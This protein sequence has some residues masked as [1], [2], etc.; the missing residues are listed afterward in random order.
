MI[1]HH[2][3]DLLKMFSTDPRIPIKFNEKSGEYSLTVNAD[4]GV[5]MV[6]CA[7]CGN[8]MTDGSKSVSRRE[9]SCEH[10]A[11]LSLEPESS[12]RFRTEEREYWLY[13]RNSRMVRLFYC[14]VCGRRLPLHKNDSRFYKKSEAEVAEL[15]KRFRNITTIDLALEQF[16]PAD[17]QHGRTVDYIYPKGRRTRIGHKRALFYDHLAETVT[18]VVIE[19]LDGGLDVKFYPKEKSR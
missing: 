18:V 8:K 12:V 3:C 6:Y 2:I 9:G 13:G 15:V 7:F 1:H 14:P 5:M 17:V 19:K 16:G 10:L 4:I 11:E